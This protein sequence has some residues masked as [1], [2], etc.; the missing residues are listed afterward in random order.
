L[1]RNFINRTIVKLINKV[2]GKRKKGKGKGKTKK[3]ISKVGIEQ[4]EYKTK[5]KST[6][7]ANKNS[8]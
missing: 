1:S 6:K 3:Q 5:K 7:K 4:K 8:H 2:E